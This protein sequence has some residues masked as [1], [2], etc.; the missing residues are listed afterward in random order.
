MAKR[1]I[2]ALPKAAK[3]EPEQE[4]D[5]GRDLVLGGYRGKAQ[6][7]TGRHS[8]FTQ[9]KADKFIQVLADSCNV[10]LAARAIKRSIGNIYHHRQ[11]D[12]E[13][14]AAWDQALSIGYARLEMMMLERALHGVEKLVVLKSGETKVMR[15]YSDRVALSLLRL[16]RENVAEIDSGVDEQEYRE[17]CERIIERLSRLRERDQEDEAERGLETKGSADAIALIKYALRRG[18]RAVDAIAK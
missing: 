13:F 8:D 2:E 7:R 1:K 5:A 16:H 12:A 4:N 14:R 3:A 18:N 10:S 17:A 15:E 9:A 6:K 11:K